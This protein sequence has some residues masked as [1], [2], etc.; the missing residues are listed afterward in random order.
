MSDKPVVVVQ[1]ALAPRVRLT[2]TTAQSF[3]LTKRAI[4]HK[5]ARGQWLEGREYHRA[6]DG[7]WIDVKGVMQWVAPVPG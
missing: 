2:D 3:G 5:I 1:V 7:I 4:E 6:P